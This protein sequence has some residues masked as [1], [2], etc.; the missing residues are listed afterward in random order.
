VFIK[1]IIPTCI[2]LLCL[3]YVNSFKTMTRKKKDGK[4]VSQGSTEGLVNYNEH[5]GAVDADDEEM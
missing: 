4:E 2:S 3:F 5:M 1:L